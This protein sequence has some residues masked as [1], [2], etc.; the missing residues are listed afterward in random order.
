MIATNNHDKICTLIAICICNRK[1]KDPVLVI[2]ELLGEHSQ[3]DF[4]NNELVSLHLITI[5]NILVNKVK[6][7]KLSL[8]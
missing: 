5:N 1:I 4:V 7:D 8:Q 2:V 3:R 6:R